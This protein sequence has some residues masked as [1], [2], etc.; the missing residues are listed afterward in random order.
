MKAIPCI[1]LS[2][3]VPITFSLTSCAPTSSASAGNA[4]QGYDLGKTKGYQ[5]GHGGLSRTP[6]RHAVSYSE[7]DRAEFF[8]GYED[9]YNAGIKPGAAAPVAEENTGNGFHSDGV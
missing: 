6:S 1:L 3:L 7:A 4:L 5:D 9:G 2:L 8:R